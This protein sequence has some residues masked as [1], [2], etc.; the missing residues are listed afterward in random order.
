MS[1]GRPLVVP[2]ELG[3]RTGGRFTG[4]LIPGLIGTMMPAGS[5]EVTEPHS[6]T[7]AVWPGGNA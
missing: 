5:V 7:A 6:R 3:V 4:D 2:L 1:I